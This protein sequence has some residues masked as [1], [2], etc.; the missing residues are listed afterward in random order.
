MIC[1]TNEQK[2]EVAAYFRENMPEFAAID[3]ATVARTINKACL[4]I[5]EFIQ[6]HLHRKYKNCCHK[7]A[8]LNEILANWVAHILDLTD[9]LSVAQGAEALPIEQRRVASSLSE[10]GLS[11][12]FEQAKPT[13]ETPEAIYDYLSKSAYGDNAKML[14][15][16]C[17]TGACG[18]LIV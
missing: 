10:G 14:I 6:T 13:G 9:A 16:A 12:S 2:K 1:L 18:V 7:K 17:L 8:V 5:P 11:A 15:E 3:D 4:Y